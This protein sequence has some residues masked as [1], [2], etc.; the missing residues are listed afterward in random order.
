VML[1][2]LESNHLVFQH[3][4]LSSNRSRM[5]NIFVECDDTSLT[6]I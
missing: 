3:T 2:E 5:S 1:K 4:H 6:L